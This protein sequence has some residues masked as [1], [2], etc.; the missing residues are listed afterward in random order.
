MKYLLYPFLLSLPYVSSAQDK[1]QCVQYHDGVFYSY[2]KNSGSQYIDYRSGS[3]VK[4]IEV[5]KTDTSYWSVKW[6]DPCTYELKLQSGGTLKPADKQFMKEHSL[7]YHITATG[8]DYYTFE[9]FVDKLNTISVN[10]DTCWLRPSVNHLKKP[11][12]TQIQN[13]TI[14]RR[15][16]FSD[17]SQYA[18][19]YIYRSKKINQML[20]DYPVYLN[21]NLLFVAHNNSSAIYK[22]LREGPASFFGKFEKNTTNATVDFKFGKKYFLKCDIHIGFYAKPDLKPVDEEKGREEFGNIGG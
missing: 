9:G 4:E 2:P 3:T 10:N 19:L 22:I 1:N 12:F 18:V 15:Q 6:L 7:V 16:K 21:D 5:G 11:L 17:T 20:I 14:L 13:E 8:K